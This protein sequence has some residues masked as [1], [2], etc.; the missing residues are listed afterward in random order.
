MR[1]QKAEGKITLWGTVRDGRGRLAIPAARLVRLHRVRRHGFTMIELLAVISVIGVLIGLLLPAVQA[2]R[3]HARRTQCESNLY[4]L[5]LALRNYEM[6]HTVLPPGTVEPSGPVENTPLGFQQSWLMAIQPWLDPPL[7]A[8]IR[9]DQ[10][11]YAPANLLILLKA[12]PRERYTG[13]LQCPSD[14]DSIGTDYAACHDDRDKPIDEDDHGVFFRNSGIRSLDIP[15]G[16]A[17]TIFLGEKRFYPPEWGW[18]SGTRA[19]LRTVGVPLPTKSQSESSESNDYLGQFESWGQPYAAEQFLSLIRPDLVSHWDEN[20]PE[21]LLEG[22]V[23]LTDAEAIKK[24]QEL[25]KVPPGK[26]IIGGFGSYHSG[27][28]NFLFGDLSVRGISIYI[29]NRL[30]RSL[31]HRADGEG[32]GATF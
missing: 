11:V 21:A 2:A 16:L 26:P 12:Q 4:Q 28:V 20:H 7:G 15:D 1:W 23:A 9:Y 5:G 25:A 13:V 8:Q 19:N 14:R 32:L 17:H 29:D 6:A 10:S 22:P 30:Y 24:I 27:V 31:G 18:M 3:E